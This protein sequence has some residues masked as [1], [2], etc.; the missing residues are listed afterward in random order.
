MARFTVAPVCPECLAGIEPLGAA[1]ICA[2]CGLP[3]ETLEPL[4]GVSLCGLCRRGATDFD[5]ARGYGA[6]Q[7]DLRR[8]IHLLKYDGMEPLARPLASRLAAL[9][10]QAGPVEALLPVPLDRSRR[11]HRGFNQAEL[12]A[13]HLSRAAGVRLET[14]V[15]VRA[16]RTEPQ[17]GLTHHQR[18]DN[19]RGAFRVRRPELVAGRNIALVDDVI[20]T[21]A[22]AAACARA[23]KQA[24]AA[25]VVVLALARARLG[26]GVLAPPRQEAA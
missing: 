8:L 24:G 10:A 17:A 19:V 25:R 22:T 18:R 12:L 26:P 14:R 3:F 20:T 16:R 11:R 1:G 13:R 9:L 4:H 15:L 5:W 6:Y 7:G 2:R 21:G 23:L